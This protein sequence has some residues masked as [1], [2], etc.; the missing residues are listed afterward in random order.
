[1]EG[2]SRSTAGV[3]QLENKIQDLEDRLRSEERWTVRPSDHGLPPH[4]HL[5]K[6]QTEAMLS[7]PSSPVCEKGEE[8]CFG[9]PTTSGEETQRTQ[10]DDGR[11]ERG[12]H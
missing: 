1:M 10:H 9:V 11:G 12:A 4:L 5:Y 3:S 6:D 2:Q 8:L 7:V